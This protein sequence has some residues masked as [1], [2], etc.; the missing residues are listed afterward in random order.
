[1]QKIS[2]DIKLQLAFWGLRASIGLLFITVGIGKFNDSFLKYL[3]DVGLPTELQI[4]IALAECIGGTFLIIG[5]LTRVSSGILGVIMLGA[6]IIK[7]ISI[8]FEIAA[9]E[10]DLILLS[11]CILILVVGSGKVSLVR[12]LRI[13]EILK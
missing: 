2:E 9:I 11:G 4:P 1:M 12:R 8:P 10:T 6:I 7:Q 13:P 5:F 3:L